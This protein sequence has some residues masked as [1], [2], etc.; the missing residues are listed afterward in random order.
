MILPGNLLVV[1]CFDEARRLPVAAF[2]AALARGDLSC[3]FVDDGSTDGTAEILAAM[4]GRHPRHADL[5]RRAPNR[6]KADAV[7]A[8][9]A[10]AESMAPRYVGYWDADLSTPLDAVLTAS[11]GCSTSI[12]TATSCWDH[13]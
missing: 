5:L 4:V 2:D 3:L 9:M 1:P 8:G 10:A 13:A 12:R 11:R 7:R 6:G